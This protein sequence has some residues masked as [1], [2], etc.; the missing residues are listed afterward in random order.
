MR[1]RDVLPSFVEAMAGGE[2]L[3]PNTVRAY[4]A[5]AYAL[6]R[7]IGRTADL[8]DLSP[9]DIEQFAEHLLASG[10][11]RSSAR[12]RIAGIRKF[13]AWLCDEGW[14]DTN[15]AIHCN[16]KPARERSLPQALSTQDTA[17]LLIHLR[18]KSEGGRR[19]AGHRHT[20]ATS[21]YLASALMV[22]TGVRVGE[23]TALT[24]GD[25]D[26]VGGSIRVLGKGR[27]E[28]VVYL[29]TGS[30]LSSLADYVAERA[31]ALTDP[32]IANRFGQALT[33]AAL[34]DRIGRAARRAGI[35]RHVTPHMLRH[36]CATQLLDAGVDIR[37]VQRLLG[38]ASITTTEIYTHVSDISLR[39]VICSADVI[40]TILRTR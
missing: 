21:T 3:S 7:F 15:P 20:P 17:R 32:L 30:L 8:A 4:L 9:A 6:E 1:I 29:P 5:D 27:R 16:I 22:A 13:C 10:L 35:E 34:R 36:T 39:R 19:A 25:A 33:T 31:A 38:H 18:S 37:M 2:D 14:L 23:L 26:I 11:K 12:R 40:G 24:F 28:R